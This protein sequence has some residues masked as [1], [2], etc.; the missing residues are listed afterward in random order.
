MA[1]SIAANCSDNCYAMNL[2]K[3]RGE[4]YLCICGLSQGSTDIATTA[5]IAK[6]I[7]TIIK[8][9]YPVIN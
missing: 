6:I 4:K 8:G 7:I 3:K 9:K 1:S 5:T 2:L